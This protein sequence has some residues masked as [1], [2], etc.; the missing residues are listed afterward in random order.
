MNARALA[1]LAAAGAVLLLLWPRRASA[2]TAVGGSNA[3]SSFLGFQLDLPS[4]PDGLEDFVSN[5]RGWTGT[6]AAFAAD[7]ERAERAN[8]IPAGLLSRLLWQESRF[9]PTA[10]NKASGAQG[11]AQVMPATARAPGFGVAPLADPFNAAQAIA[12]AGAYLAAMKRYVG[13]WGLALAAYN[14]G[15]GYVKN[16]ARSSWPAET[17]A[18]VRDITA[19]VPVT[20]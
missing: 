13:T 19:D 10:V 2:S 20:V 18:Y 4:L 17:V 3:G 8:G 5:L 9:K 1:A 12:F 16:K 14:W 7:V 11:I 15:P 6:P